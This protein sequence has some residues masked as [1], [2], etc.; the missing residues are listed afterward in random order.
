ML[1]AP[2]QQEKARGNH[3]PAIDILVGIKQDGMDGSLV[4]V[5]FPDKGFRI[6]CQIHGGL[7]H[8]QVGQIHVA[9]YR[10]DHL[11]GQCPS[12]LHQNPAGYV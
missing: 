9:V 8:I 7:V 4:R 10:S 5:K 12:F 3:Y 6:P 1:V 11:K 2:D